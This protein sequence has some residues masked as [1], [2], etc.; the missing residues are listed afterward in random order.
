MVEEEAYDPN[1][2]RIGDVMTGSVEVTTADATV[3]AVA[4]KMRDS[5]VGMIPVCEDDRLVGVLTDRDITVRSTAKGLDPKKTRIR[6]V[7]TPQVLYCFDDQ[8]VAEAGHRM[9]Q[10]AVRRLIV[11][12]R[13]KRMVGIISLDDLV[14]LPGEEKR[15]GEV[16]EHVT[17]PPTT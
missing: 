15:V 14:R 6:E 4:A 13:Q 7:M 17:Q 2:I 1:L 9:E 3:A 10:K 8:L 16:L 11:L 5:A 12:N